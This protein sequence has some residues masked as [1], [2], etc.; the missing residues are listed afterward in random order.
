MIYIHAYDIDKDIKAKS[1]DLLQQNLNYYLGDKQDIAISYNKNGKPYVNGIHF[2]VSHCQNILL[3]AFSK[4]GE[5][6]IDAEHQNTRRKIQALAERYF[7]KD[8]SEFL[9]TLNLKK[10][11]TMF[12]NLWSSKEAVCK[13]QGGRLW[14]YLADSYLDENNTIKTMQHGLYISQLQDIKNFSISLASNFE[15]QKRVF[16]HE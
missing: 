5:L 8:E 9:S 16:I 13:A 11:I 4:T 15:S 12:Y 6:G 1:K 3:Q 7:H 14:Y 2:S 10:A